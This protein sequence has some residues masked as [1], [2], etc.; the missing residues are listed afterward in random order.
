MTR[1][2]WMGAGVALALGLAGA[3]GVAFAQ[4][5]GRGDDRGW[6][7]P[8]REWGG[9][10]WRDDD[11]RDR[12]EERRR[13]WEERRN[14][15]WSDGEG[16]GDEG[17][18]WRGGGTRQGMGPG[19]GMGMHRY[20]MGMH[21]R[22]GMHGGMGMRGGMGGDPVRRGQMML[23]RAFE[24]FDRNLDGTIEWSEVQMVL[25][26]RFE[27]LDQDGDGAITRADIEARLG[28]RLE[29]MGRFTGRPLP[30]ERR[31]EMVNRAVERFMGRFGKGAD[32]RVTR[33]EFAG[34]FEPIF[35]AM[36]RTGDGR[37]TRPQV[38]EFLVVMRA[39]RG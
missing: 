25:G 30:Q 9:E 14:E 18:G 38:E 35:R 5:W 10:R 26:R 34:S 11:M 21:G 24:L 22:Y 12:W 39:L 15:R 29:R 16:R 19:D 4:G 2:A 23:D 33:E 20:G 37:L 27:R 1:K 6:D 3:S 13:R 8:R 17:R 36:N 31:T 7:G 32:G 28:Q